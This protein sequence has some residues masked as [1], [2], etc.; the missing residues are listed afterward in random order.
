M[1]REIEIDDLSEYVDENTTIVIDADGLAFKPATILDENFIIVKHKPSGA[2]K[3]LKNITEF[4]GQTKAVAANS[5]LGTLNQKRIIKGE[6]PYTLEEFEV[7]PSQRPKLPLKVA[8]QNIDAHIKAILDHTGCSKYL[9]VMGSGKNKRHKLPLPEQYK[10]NRDGT[11][12]PLSLKECRNYLKDNY[13]TEVVKG[14]EADE[15]ISMYAWLGY[16]DYLK[17]GKFSY[18]VSSNDKDAT[19]SAG[20]LFNWDRDGSIF[21]HPKP[22][23]IKPFHESVG[24]V[25]LVKGKIKAYGLMQIVHQ[26]LLGDSSDLYFAFKKVNTDYKLGDAGLFKKLYGIETQKEALQVLVDCYKEAFPTG[27]VVYEDFNGN[28]QDLHWLDWLEMQFTCAYMP[29]S[30]NDP[31][32]MTKLLNHYGV[33]YKDEELNLEGVS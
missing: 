4:K 8:T 25:D 26:V 11:L 5:W 29:R 24:G 27:R 14:I 33:D 23:L 28:Q 9:M 16:Q 7:T 10:S 15:I 19:Q 32:T 21:K 2:E 3:E 31:L 30:L 18:I 6:D 1:F 20:I 12:S 13:P 17:T 22:I